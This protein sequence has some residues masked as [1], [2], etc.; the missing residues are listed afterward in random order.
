VA[1]EFDKPSGGPSQTVFV[2]HGSAEQIR[3]SLANLVAKPDVVLETAPAEFKT[4][5]FRSLGLKVEP[6]DSLEA[7]RQ[8]GSD[9]A[10]AVVEENVEK[11][12]AQTD[13]LNLDR[14]LKRSK[15]PTEPAGARGGAAFAAPMTDSKQSATADE[16]PQSSAESQ[17]DPAD[18]VGGQAMV[19]SIRERKDVAENRTSIYILFRLSSA[20][21][22]PAPADRSGD[23]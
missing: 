22:R 17:A 9:V 3:Q 20:A 10:S 18:R 15:Q 5:F 4:S 19:P 21:A 16:R 12:K 11:D 1:L 13:P 8:S 23:H 2:V 6:T 7:A 14:L